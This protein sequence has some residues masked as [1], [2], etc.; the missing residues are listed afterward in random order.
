MSE[1]SE[2]GAD[3]GFGDF[4]ILRADERLVGPQGP[5]KLGNKAYRVLLMLAE[6]Q[7]RLLTKYELF[8]SV[9]DGMY[10]SESA[11]TSVVKELRRALGD[12][13]TA[14]RYIESVYG[15]GYRLLASVAELDGAASGPV[16][17]AAPSPQAG[18]GTGSLG[19][20]PLLLMPPFDDSALRDSHPFLGA[21]LHEEAL[22]VLS[23][24]RD[25]RLVS[26]AAPEGR[27]EGGPF[28]ERDYRL[29]VRLFADGDTVRAFV[30]MTR[31]AN[32]AIIW[33]DQIAIAPANPSQGVETLTRRVAAAALPRLHD[34]VL[35]HLPQQPDDAYDHYFANRFRMRSLDG[36]EEARA[37]AAAWERLIAEHPGFLQAYPPLIRL[38]NTDYCFTGLGSSGPAERGRA[39][40]LAHRAIAL[41]PTESHLHTVKG[42]C[43]LWAGEAALAREH[44][45]QAIG[46]NPYNQARLVEVATGLMFL[47]ELD[48]A[49]ELLDRCRTLAAFEAEA[50]HEEE[51]LL[52]LLREEFEAAAEKLAR[53]RHAHPDDR[54]I[55]RPVKAGFYALVAAAGAG[56]ADLAERRLHWRALI[57]ELWSAAEPLDDERL[58]QW[59]LFHNPFQTER[60]RAWLLALFDRALAAPDPVAARGRGRRTTPGA[61]PISAAS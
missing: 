11:L 35:R 34:D 52:H 61:A 26:D 56:A 57:E 25:I 9:W 8:S 33:T 47:D 43:H 13:S 39:Y 49:A 7:G 58:R 32:K 59:V 17:A 20:P 54:T 2:A 5:V 10:V 15:R 45:D 60:R 42:W 22:I 48:R 1:Q 4:Q 41:D 16:A 36:V 53:A 40:E 55:A 24:F 21:I 38:Y 12:S 44:F 18:A 23:R 51:G 27:E 19:E 31:L 50:P 3:L 46:L 29:T 28:G 37:V 30:R 14:P 6:R